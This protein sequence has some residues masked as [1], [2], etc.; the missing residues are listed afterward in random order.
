MTAARRYSSFYVLLVAAA[1]LAGSA[2]PADAR[3]VGQALQIQATAFGQ[4]VQIVLQDWATA[5]ADGGVTLFA[6]GSPGGPLAARVAFLPPFEKDLEA[7]ILPRWNFNGVPPGTYYVVMVSG[8]VGTPSVAPSAWRTLVVGGACPGVPGIGVVSRDSAGQSPGTLRLLMSSADGCATSFDLDAGVTPGGLEIGRFTAIPGLLVVPTPPPGTYYVRARGRNAAGVGAVSDVLA[9]KEPACQSGL[10]E[11]TPH[12][13][14][15][16][17]ATVVGNTVTLTW[18]ITPGGTPQT[19]QE[20]V[21]DY[22][23]AGPQQPAPTILLPATATSLS[24]TVPSGAYALLLLG[25]N[26]CGKSDFSD[27]RFTVP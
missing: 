24:A 4:L 16:F 10:G 23:R 6:S 13:P 26:G 5:E 20:L 8:I 17:R 19:Y 27:L 9:I 14:N 21:L 22:L 7:G 2:R 15:N 25:G 3:T 1:L 11:S 18:T 12:G